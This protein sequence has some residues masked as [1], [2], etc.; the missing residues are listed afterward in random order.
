MRTLQEVKQAVIDAVERRGEEIIAMGEEVWRNPEPGYKEFKTSKLATAKLRSLGLEVKENLAITGMRADLASSRPGP[1]LA[2]LG[3]MDSLI[4]PGHPECDKRTGAVHSCG[5]N[6][7]ITAM[8]GAAMALVDAHAIDDLSGKIAFIGTPAEECIELEWRNQLIAEGRIGALGGK[9]ELIREGVFNDID[10]ALM[11]HIGNRRHY[12]TADHNGFV[13]KTVVFKGRSCHAAA[14]ANGVNAV[15]VA[16]L[17]VQALG[18][19]NATFPDEARVHGII[20]SGGDAVNVIPDRAVLEYL[21]RAP[22]LEAIERLSRSFDRAMKGA[23]LALGAEVEIRTT[24]G[25]MPLDNDRA[26]SDLLVEVVKEHIPNSGEFKVKTIFAKSSTDMGDVSVIMPAAHCDVPG[27]GGRSHGVDYFIADKHTAYV[28]NAKI[29]ALMAVE[30]L[31]G[32]AARGRRIAA[33]REGKLS[34]DEFIRRTDA[35]NSVENFSE[36]QIAK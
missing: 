11:N 27:S 4:I 9:P 2:L 33:N 15:H 10:M 6:S 18:L 5:H 35:L 17:A 30:L 13:C 34:V 19:L 31:Y 12:G 3:E 21:V 1:A 8:V 20:T 32:D 14:P 26:L 23:A 36:S 25:Y 16:T 7:H 29:M 28:D 24:A 22:T